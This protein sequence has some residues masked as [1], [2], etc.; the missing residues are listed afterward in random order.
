MLLLLLLL[1]LILLLLLLLLPSSPSLL[2]MAVAK[3]CRLGHCIPSFL[4]H[5]VPCHN[6]AGVWYRGYSL[7]FWMNQ[8]ARPFLT[9]FFFCCLC[10]GEGAPVWWGCLTLEP[11]NA[12]REKNACSCVVGVS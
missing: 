5:G 8:T 6:L 10:C 1:L 2:L 7:K 4:F 12:S 11:I 3:P 9:F